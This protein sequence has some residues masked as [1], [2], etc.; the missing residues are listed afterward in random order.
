[1]AASAEAVNADPALRVAVLHAM[2]RGIGDVLIW[3]HGQPDGIERGLDVVEHE[4]SSAGRTF[5]G[6]AL[7]AL[8]LS[9]A[10][11]RRET[12]RGRTSLRAYSDLTPAVATSLA[13]R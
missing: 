10:V 13:Q 12:F 6:H 7:A 3:G 1:M 4:L 2:K 5:K 8:G 11:G 9:E